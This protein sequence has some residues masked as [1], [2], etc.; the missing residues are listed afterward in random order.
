MG[1]GENALEALGLL[2]H[3]PSEPYFDYV[4][5]IAENP[6]A[7]KVK[8]ADLKHNSDITRLNHKPTKTDCKRLHKY[9]LAV[10]ILENGLSYRYEEPCYEE[11]A[12]EDD[13]CYSVDPCDYGSFLDS[14]HYGMIA[15][16]VFLRTQFEIE[17]TVLQ[18]ELNHYRECLIDCTWMMLRDDPEWHFIQK[19]RAGVLDAKLLPAK[20]GDRFF[21]DI[22]YTLKNYPI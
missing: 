19:Y 8:M 3:D 7:T 20:E 6:L 17:E 4:K 16:E 5:S 14:F 18:K 15:A 12:H 13:H 11:V 10:M 2:T 1:F 21:G 22:E 9:S